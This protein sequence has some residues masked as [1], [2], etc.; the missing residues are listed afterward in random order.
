MIFSK[1]DDETLENE[2]PWQRIAKSNGNMA[3][4]DCFLLI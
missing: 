4:S 2:H 3:K 1:D